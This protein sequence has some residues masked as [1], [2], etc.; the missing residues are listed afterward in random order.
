MGEE[1]QILF[2]GSELVCL[3]ALHTERD[4]AGMRGAMWRGGAHPGS[5][6]TGNVAEKMRSGTA[7]GLAPRRV[8]IKLLLAQSY[9]KTS[10]L[11]SFCNESS[12][13]FIF[14]CD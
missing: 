1:E 6:Y 10:I 14:F 13:I 2:G 12:F 4:P 9:L 7:P 5:P 8:R 11:T 3:K